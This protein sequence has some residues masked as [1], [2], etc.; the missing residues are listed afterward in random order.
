MFSSLLEPK[1]RIA[2]QV[3]GSRIY[4]VRVRC[5]GNAGPS[6]KS[7]GDLREKVT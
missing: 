7:T 3:P 2:R 4:S 6:S 5:N 1:D